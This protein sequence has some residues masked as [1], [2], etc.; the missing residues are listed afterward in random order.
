MFSISSSLHLKGVLNVFELSALKLCES[1]LNSIRA[2]HKTNFRISLFQSILNYLETPK[3]ALGHFKVPSKNLDPIKNSLR[4][5]G[6]RLLNFL[7]AIEESIPEVNTV[8]VYT[9]RKLCRN[10]E[11]YLV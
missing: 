6:A 5:R 11:Q 2:E 1:A 8:A 9:F 7:I 3:D 10:I 4:T